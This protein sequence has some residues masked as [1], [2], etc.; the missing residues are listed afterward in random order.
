MTFAA[1]AGH[2][3]LLVVLSTLHFRIVDNDI[4]WKILVPLNVEIL[5]YKHS[6]CSSNLLFQTC[7]FYSF[8]SYWNSAYPPLLYGIDSCR[9]A[10]AKPK[11]P[12]T[13]MKKGPY[14]ANEF[15]ASGSVYTHMVLNKRERIFRV[16]FFFIG[17]KHS[18]GLSKE[19][20]KYYNI[21]FNFVWV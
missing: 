7:P 3:L 10:E 19:H 16:Y 13:F 14:A 9:N 12:G 2:G 21:V 20:Q 8:P 5:P 4:H 17:H 11:S 18:I 6:L 15:S 1:L